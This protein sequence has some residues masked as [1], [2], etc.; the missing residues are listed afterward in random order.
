MVSEDMRSMGD[1]TL[2]PADAYDGDLELYDNHMEKYK[3]KKVTK[4]RIPSV[5][6]QA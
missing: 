1:L 6:T 3:A 2:D 4:R 5:T